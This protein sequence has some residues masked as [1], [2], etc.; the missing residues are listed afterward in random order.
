MRDPFGCTS[1]AVCFCKRTDGRGCKAAAHASET[2]RDRMAGLDHCGTK[3]PD[4]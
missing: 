3:R 1:A 2:F 4:F